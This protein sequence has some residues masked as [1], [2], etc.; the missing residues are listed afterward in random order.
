M[1]ILGPLMRPRLAP[2]PILQFARGIRTKNR[3]FDDDEDYRRASIW[4]N[5]SQH[6]EWGECHYQLSFRDFKDKH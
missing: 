3:T 4:H 6:Q 2:A 5:V 1:S